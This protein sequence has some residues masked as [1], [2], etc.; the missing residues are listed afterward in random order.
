MNNLFKGGGGV[1]CPNGT[2]YIN[3]FKCNHRYGGEQREIFFA[4]FTRVGRFRKGFSAEN[5]PLR[6]K[7]GRIKVG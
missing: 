4:V 1:H 7:E 2:K 3:T 5:L 6:R